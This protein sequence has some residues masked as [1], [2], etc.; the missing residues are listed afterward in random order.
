MGGAIT[1]LGTEG[2]DG[3]GE[4]GGFGGAKD[5]GDSVGNDGDVDGV[6]TDMSV[7]LGSRKMVLVNPL[8]AATNV[9]QDGCI[10]TGFAGGKHNSTM[11]QNSQESRREYWATCSF[12]CSFARAAHSFGHTAHSLAHSLTSSL[13]P[14]LTHSRAHSLPSSWEKE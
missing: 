3:G 13:T 1:V 4:D 11:V 12:V 6:G 5:S 8:D 7:R 9:V 14:E 10:M 2:G